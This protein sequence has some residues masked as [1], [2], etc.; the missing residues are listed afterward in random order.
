MTRQIKKI[1]TAMMVAYI[2]SLLIVAALIGG[3][4]AFFDTPFAFAVLI[5]LIYTLPVLI[6]VIEAASCLIRLKESQWHI[7]IYNGMTMLIALCGVI[8]AFAGN[9]M[10]YF[11]LILAALLLI[12]ELIHY[13]RNK[14]ESNLVS[15][16]KQKSFWVIV[17]GIV[18]I[19][20]LCAGGYRSLLDAENKTDPL[21]SITYRMEDMEDKASG[22]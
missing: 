18:L 4:T 10:I 3:E 22:S 2:P 16:F 9:E 6:G 13:I 8:L 20:T 21:L 11:S 19:V 1:L 12:M 14:R 7:S 15:F 5:I 17:L